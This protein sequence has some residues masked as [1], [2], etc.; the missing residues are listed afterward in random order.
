[1]RPIQIVFVALSL[2][3]FLGAFW[4]RSHPVHE[5]L[6]LFPDRPAYLFSY[7]D[8]SSGGTS[9]VRAMERLDDGM[10]FSF[11]LGPSRSAFAG[12]GADFAGPGRNRKGVD[13]SGFDAIELDLRVGSPLTLKVVLTGFD[14]TIWKEGDW[15]SRRYSEARIE[16]PPDGKV[17]IPL[18]RFVL[19]S[20]WLDRGLVAPTDTGRSFDQVQ[21]FAIQAVAGRK[22]PDGKE[23][24]ILVKDLRAVRDLPRAGAWIWLVP[25]LLASAAVPWRSLRIRRAALVA[26]GVAPRALEPVPLPL[27]NESDDLVA[28]LSEHLARNYQRAELDAATVCRETGIPRS[29]LSEIVKTGF[30]TAFKAH[31]N[32]LRLKE[33]ARLLS[34]TD[35][36]VA[37][38]GFAVGYN[39]VAHFHRVF[40]ERHGVPPGEYRSKTQKAAAPGDA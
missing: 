28:R 40:R 32:D 2:A 23:D 29:R 1:M 27:R 21:T 6:R 39:S 35:R 16:N 26:P 19:Q 31:L 5:E 34:S 17:R 12:A 8:R 13:L 7:D 36:G 22:P 18:E 38:I 9:E 25:L 4:L 3:S 14:S 20:W 33:A 24:T 37:E 15:S 10:R 30:G 11:L